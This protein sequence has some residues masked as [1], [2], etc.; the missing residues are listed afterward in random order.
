M[1]RLLVLPLLGLLGA[2]GA[3]AASGT[4]PTFPSHK[5]FVCKYVGTPGVD[6]RL[7]T[8]DNP[9]WVDIT[10]LANFVALGDFFNDEQGRSVAIAFDTGQPEPAVAECPT[11]PSPDDDHDQ[12]RNDDH[13]DDAD[14]HVRPTTSGPTTTFPTPTPFAIEVEPLCPD[15]T[16]PLIAITFGD[17]PDLDGLTGTLT[18]STGGSVPLTFE[19]DATVNIPYPASAGTGPVTMTYTLG[20]ESVTRSTTFPEACAPATTTTTGPRRDHRH[21]HVPGDTTTTRPRRRRAD[22][23]DA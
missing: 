4:D 17:R 7:Q 15:G 21:D 16:L 11:A 19:V 12:A 22:D 2:C 10:S 23:D 6:E 20:A 9:I 3:S 8:G 14:D 5:V 18:F 13:D 1:R